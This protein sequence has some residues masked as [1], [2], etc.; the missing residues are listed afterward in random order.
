MKIFLNRLAAFFV[1][2]IF[3]YLLLSLFNWNIDYFNW[4]GISQFIFCCTLAFLLLFRP[5]FSKK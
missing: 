1:L 2:L 5:E 3:G 4:N